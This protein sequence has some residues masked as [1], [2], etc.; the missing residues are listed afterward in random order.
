MMKKIIISI[1]IFGFF[2]SPIYFGANLPRRSV[3]KA[4]FPDDLPGPHLMPD[5][6]FYFLKI[7]YEKVVIFFTFNLAKRAERYKTFAE[8]RLYEGQEMIK[9][10]K[11]DLAN[12]EKDLYKYYLNKAQ[13]ALEKAIQ[14]AMEKKKEQVAQ[15]LQKT[16][17]DIK[18]KLKESI[19]L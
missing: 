8:K 10:G 4:G 13:S 11:Q 6:P 19:K 15:E 16:L 3:A 9:E 7:W 1:I 2:F 5:S 14:K 18:N 17:E 12:K